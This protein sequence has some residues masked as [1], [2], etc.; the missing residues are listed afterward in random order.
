MEYLAAQQ[1]FDF[2]YEECEEGVNILRLESE[3]EACTWIPLHIFQDILSPETLK[4]LIDKVQIT[5]F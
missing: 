2:L 4:V 1:T 3:F 5:I